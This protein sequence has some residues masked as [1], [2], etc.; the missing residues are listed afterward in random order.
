MFPWVVI[1]MMTRPEDTTKAAHPLRS[2]TST[3]D[4]TGTPGSSFSSVGSIISAPSSIDDEPEVLQQ[5]AKR[6]KEV[7]TDIGRDNAPRKL[8]PD[9]TIELTREA[10]DNGI[11]ETK[12]S[13]AG[14]EDVS[15]VVRPKL[16]I[17]LGH[18][19]IAQIPEGVVDIIKDEVERYSFFFMFLI[20]GLELTWIG[21]HYRTIT[22][23]IY[24]I[25]L[26]NAVTYDT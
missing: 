9:E 13:L 24:L 14:N 15:D 1:D 23:F 11:Q 25:A 26:Q 17:D 21:F 19:H 10:V 20:V 16:T 5:T 22:F 7:K 3:E 2:E 8:T 6:V 18:S 12:R 4:M